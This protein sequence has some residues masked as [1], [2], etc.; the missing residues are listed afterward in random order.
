MR[1]SGFTLLELLVVIAIIGVLIALLLPA[2]QHVR[3]AANRTVCANN[4]RQIGIAVHAYEALN[5][6]IP[7]AWNPENAFSSPPVDTMSGVKGTIHFLLLGQLDQ[8]PLYRNANKDSANAADSVLPV[9]LCPSEPSLSSNINEVGFA[10]TNYVANLMVFSPTS[11]RPLVSAMPDGTSV[12]VMFVERYK[13]CDSYQPAWAN[14]PAA[15]GG[16]N[17]TPVFGWKEYLVRASNPN[18]VPCP[19]GPYFS[20]GT[21]GFQINPS[22]GACDPT[23]TQGP[24]P[25][26][27]V[28]LLGDGGVRGVSAGVSVTTWVYVCTPNDL[29]PLGPDWLE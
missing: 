24:H 3:E 8:Y 12:T 11:P 19:G 10:S 5:R 27:M 25:S 2:V 20:N 15:A 1:R 6:F 4:L 28:V 17:D 16:F 18:N 23:V 13:N 21:R 9:F 26:G 29:H 7:P 22:V 14:Y